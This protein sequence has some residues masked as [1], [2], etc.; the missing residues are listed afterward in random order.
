MFVG[1]IS[2]SY[3]LALQLFVSFGLLNDP[4]PLIPTFSLLFP[5][6]DFHNL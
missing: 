4:F 2:S 5:M 1:C 3:S 6:I